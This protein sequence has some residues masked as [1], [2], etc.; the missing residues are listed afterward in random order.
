M[1]LKRSSR[2]MVASSAGISWMLSR[3][4][5]CGASPLGHQGPCGGPRWRLRRGKPAL[6][7]GVAPSVRRSRPAKRVHRGASRNQ[8][9]QEERRRIAR[10]RGPEQPSDASQTAMRVAQRL[11]VLD[12]ARVTAAVQGIPARHGKAG[13]VADVVQPCGCFQEIGRRDAATHG[14]VCVLMRHGPGIEGVCGVDTAVTLSVNLFTAH[15]R[16]LS[17]AQ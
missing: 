16:A 10:G 3:R 6:G 17:T 12:V 8:G 9:Y 13:R 15:I 14:E 2:P 7:A 4:G 11:G 5:S 1:C